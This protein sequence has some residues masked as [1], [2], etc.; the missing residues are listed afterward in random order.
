VSTPSNIQMRGTKPDFF[1]TGLENMAVNK[2]EDFASSPVHA[3]A[4][5]ESLY[6]KKPASAHNNK[7]K[8]FGDD[9]AALTEERD[10]LQRELAESR[11]EVMELFGKLEEL[12]SQLKEA[13]TS[14]QEAQDTIAAM[15]AETAVLKQ[16]LAEKAAND[17][18]IAALDVAL[19]EALA[20]QAAASDSAV[21]TAAELAALQATHD[22]LVYET[23]DY[24]STIASLTTQVE[25][26][27]IYAAA[28]NSKNKNA[29]GEDGVDETVPA[30]N[31]GDTG[32][33]EERIRVA[34]DA[35]RE[36]TTQEWK[37]SYEA[38]EQSYIAYKAYSDTQ[39]AE[40]DALKSTTS[41]LE[42]EL[43]ALRSELN[44][45]R[46]AAQARHT[47][48]SALQEQVATLTTTVAQRDS[49]Q[50]ILQA[51]IVRMAGANIMQIDQA[52]T[53]ATTPAAAPAPVPVPLKEHHPVS[54][55][56]SAG[57]PSLERAASGEHSGP[58]SFRRGAPPL[59][60]APSGTRTSRPPSGG[61]TGGRPVS[62]SA[63]GSPRP[64]T[65]GVA[66]DGAV[67]GEG[68]V[69]M[70]DDYHRTYYFNEATGE[71]SW[72]NPAEGA[73]LRGE[74]LQ[75]Y[76]ESGQRYWVHQVTGESAWEVSEEGEV[77]DTAGA[78]LEEDDV[79][80]AH[81]N[82]MANASI[83]DTVNSQYSATAGDYTIEL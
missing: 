40:N 6:E 47:E 36:S 56:V 24:R 45:E 80:S 63:S 65:A 82:N 67:S 77:I 57:A 41:A 30:E 25:N 14:R 70:V 61:P 21:Q 42:A 37:E 15:E 3:N 69:E 83:Y 38:L 73:V 34:C 68:W 11:Q 54:S 50:A 31:T 46:E 51:Q 1:M 53:D 9:M 43:E 17:A 35:V 64:V 62:G 66:A 55:A 71:S 33:V 27:E 22:A 28:Q 8:F 39:Q 75:T 2:G 29:G 20:S 12:E 7:V 26:L 48:S 23:S 16:A 59:S 52:I 79:S 13:V 5:F 49:V 10:G 60:R 72:A 81:L 58:P 74:W 19:A 4:D 76:D 44:A 32:D 18:A 78:D